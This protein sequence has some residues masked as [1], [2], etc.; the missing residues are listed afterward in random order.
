[1]IQTVFVYGTLKVG[2]ERE[3]CWPRPPL[4][5]RAAT[6]SGQLYDLGPYPAMLAGEDRVLGELWFLRPE[7]VDVTLRVLDE[8][9]C[10]G[11]E[12]VDLY[13]RQCI[14]CRT[15]DDGSLHAAYAY[16]LADAAEAQRHPRLTPR[17]DG[18]VAWQP[19]PTPPTRP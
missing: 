9:E 13:V 7:D 12:D 14:E 17:P 3:S 1:M 10:Y 11:V 2:E 5:V 8:V 19:R 15:L 18:L 4:A 6:T 16:F